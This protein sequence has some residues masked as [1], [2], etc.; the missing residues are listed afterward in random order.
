MEWEC[1]GKGVDQGQ[2]SA[3][4]RHIGRA[5][6][7]E[8]CQWDLCIHGPR[9]SLPEGSRWLECNVVTG[10]VGDGSEHSVTQTSQSASAT[11]TRPGCA[12]LLYIGRRAGG[13]SLLSRKEFQALDSSCCPL[14]SHLV[15]SDKFRRPYVANSARLEIIMY[16]LTYLRLIRLE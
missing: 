1:A 6:M 9:I 3:E 10:V 4:S 11:L 12:G 16:N 14:S 13:L 8:V 5:G 7:L 15:K 2:R